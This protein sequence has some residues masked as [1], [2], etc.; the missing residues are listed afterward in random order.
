MK[1]RGRVPSA[2][3]ILIM[4]HPQHVWGS[5]G[6]TLMR[7]GKH[8]FIVVIAKLVQ[9]THPASKGCDEDVLRMRKCHKSGGGCDAVDLATTQNPGGYE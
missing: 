4:A 3:M 7:V 6:E 1:S 9:T 2:L 5:V 8:H